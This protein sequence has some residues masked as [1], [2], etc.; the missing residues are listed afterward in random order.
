[1]S[2]WSSSLHHLAPRGRGEEGD[3]SGN[4]WYC[5]FIWSY[6]PNQVYTGISFAAILIFAGQTDAHLWTSS[7]ATCF[8]S[9]LLKMFK[10][11]TSTMELSMVDGSCGI[12]QMAGL[13]LR[14]GR[15]ATY[16]TE[17]FSHKLFGFFLAWWR[18]ASAWAWSYSHGICV[19]LL[20]G[21]M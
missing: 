15:I 17:T 12:G 9:W 2:R 1:M 6:W 18:R 3:C 11:F 20:L 5:L 8:L 21:T 19:A 7:L 4:C 13:H 14:H 10:L 16:P